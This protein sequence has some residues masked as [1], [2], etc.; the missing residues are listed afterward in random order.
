MLLYDFR[1]SLE[2]P[3]GDKHER[4]DTVVTLH[5]ASFYSNGSDRLSCYDL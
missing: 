1:R 5:T 2:L 4:K 3:V